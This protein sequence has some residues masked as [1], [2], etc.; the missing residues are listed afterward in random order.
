MLFPSDKRRTICAIF[1]YKKMLLLPING[2]LLN[3][4]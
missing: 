2:T 1:D 3:H 4:I